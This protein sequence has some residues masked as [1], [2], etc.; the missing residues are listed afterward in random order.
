[1][2]LLLP[3]FF[4]N[5]FCRLGRP[6]VQK[7]MIELIMQPAIK[8]PIVS[9]WKL[10]DEKFTWGKWRYTSIA[11]PRPCSCSYPYRSCSYSPCC[12][13]F[14]YP[15]WVSG[16]FPIIYYEYWLD[17]MGTFWENFWKLNIWCQKYQFI[18]KRTPVEGKKKNV[19]SQNWQ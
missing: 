3:P 11:R 4:K 14:T 7:A 1:M 15:F 19:Y 12:P 10:N 8:G 6:T 9:V 16:K 13:Y 2:A 18:D 5:F 17:P